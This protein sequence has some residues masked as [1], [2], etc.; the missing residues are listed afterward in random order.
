MR[1]SF[2][3]GVRNDLLQE[4][5]DQTKSH[6]KNRNGI[7]VPFH[8]SVNTGYSPLAVRKTYT[9]P[10]NRY[11]HVSGITLYTARWLAPTV[12]QPSLIY[13]DVY[14]DIGTPLLFYNAS[15]YDLRASSHSEL[16]PGGNFVLF[17]G[18]K[19]EIRTQNADTGGT[20]HFSATAAVNEFD[21]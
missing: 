3:S 2:Q 16:N 17:P 10:A 21:I 4:I 15:N 5:A 19:I 13:F 9:V 20:T 11:A 1:F 7:L 8:Y 18:Y 12:Y 6:V 14:D